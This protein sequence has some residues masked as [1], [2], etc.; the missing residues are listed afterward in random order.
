LL[1]SPLPL[2]D[3]DSNPVQQLSALLSAFS[4]SEF[5]SH[6]LLLLC[7]IVNAY[8]LGPVKMLLPREAL[9]VFQS[10]LFILAGGEGEQFA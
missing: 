8:L 6:G 5:F 9:T 2:L 1:A 4:N 10:T 3:L 7:G